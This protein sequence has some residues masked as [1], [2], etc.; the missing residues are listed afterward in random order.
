MGNL[1]EATGSVGDS[2]GTT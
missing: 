1:V 2:C